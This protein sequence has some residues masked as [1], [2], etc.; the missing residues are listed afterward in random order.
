MTIKYF[1]YDPLKLEPSED[2]PI[3]TTLLSVIEQLTEQFQL[4]GDQCSQQASAL[5]KQSEQIDELLTEIRQ[6]KSSVKNLNYE[7]VVF[8][9]IKTTR[10][11]SRQQL[12][13]VQSDR[14]H[15]S[16]VKLRN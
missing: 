6:L 10:M 3:V 4:Q 2:S 11:M 12:E 1:N 14:A 9:K 16:A 7:R 8:L 5:S 15:Q 13:L